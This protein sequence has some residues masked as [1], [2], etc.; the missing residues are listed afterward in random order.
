M[1][2]VP[3]RRGGEGGNQ[4]PAPQRLSG[5]PRQRPPG[6]DGT[7]NP[8]RGWTVFHVGIEDRRTI[9]KTRR[10]HAYPAAERFVYWLLLFY[11]ALTLTQGL[12]GHLKAS[13]RRGLLH[14]LSNELP[15]VGIGLQR[16]DVLLPSCRQLTR[17]VLRAALL[18][19][20]N[21]THEHTT[22]LA[23]LTDPRA[24]YLRMD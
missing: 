1:L 11:S 23:R 13:R 4:L 16:L 19:D 14:V 18:H 6:A 5:E 22:Q 3:L 15:S 9:T 8:D 20:L 24:N 12:H 2:A 17:L 21:L 10:T 7:R